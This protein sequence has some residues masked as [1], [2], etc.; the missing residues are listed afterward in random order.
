[1]ERFGEAQELRLHFLA[2]RQEL[3]VVH[4]QGVHVLEAT[5]ERVSLPRRDGRVKRFDVLIQRQVLDVELG[6][7][8][9]G[10]VADGHQEVRLP[11]AR[12]AIDEERVVRRSRILGDGPAGGDRQAVRRT[13]DKGLERELRVE[14]TGHAVLPAASLLSTS[15]EMDLRVSNT[16]W[17]W[18]ASAGKLGT[19]RK[20]S[21]SS[22]SAGVRISS[23]GRSRLLY[24]MTTGTVRMSM[25][26]SS[27]LLCRFW[28]L[29]MFSSSWRAWL[30]PTNTTPS[31]PCNTRRRVAL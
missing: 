16:P 2:V 29:S 1:L 7:E 20:L 26:C 27:R 31:A 5:A 24:C 4:Q 28:R 30:S 13:D 15:S 25:P 19:L 21:A 9:L 8:L 10:A 3:H 18:S 12:A 22:S 11:Q 17:P 23:R 6:R 14:G